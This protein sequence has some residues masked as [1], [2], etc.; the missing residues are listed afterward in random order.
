MSFHIDNIKST[1][2]KEGVQ[3]LH[4]FNCF[5]H[6]PAAIRTNI[7]D[8]L[9]FRINSINWPGASFELDQIKHKGFGLNESRVIGVG[10]EDIVITI[11]ADAE[12]KIN[13][14]FMKWI[15]LTMQINEEENQSEYINYPVNIYGGLEINIFNRIGEQ[16]TIINFIEPF[17]T[18]MGAV[19]M[20]W[21]ST[22]QIMLIPLSFKYRSYKINPKRKGQINV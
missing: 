22:N 14:L 5:I 15:E 10:F 6:P 7:A 4:A 13:N 19:Q 12:G 20:S 8:Q 18:H 16:H 2:S 21:E 11:I 1:I 9:Q 3:S 17:L